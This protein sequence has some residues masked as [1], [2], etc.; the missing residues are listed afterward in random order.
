MKSLKKKAGSYESEFHFRGCYKGIEITS[1]KI[2][3]D[4][5]FIV[6]EEYVLKVEL[7]EVSSSMLKARLIKSKR[8]DS[9]HAGL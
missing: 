6:Q 7:V 4:T 9:M 3:S 2:Y 1:L 8:I 5:A